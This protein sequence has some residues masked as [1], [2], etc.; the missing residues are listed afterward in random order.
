MRKGGYYV[1]NTLLKASGQVNEW[2]SEQVDC[3]GRQSN[4]GTS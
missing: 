3:K 1:N 4:R 2:T